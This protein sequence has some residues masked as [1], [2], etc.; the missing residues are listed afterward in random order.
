MSKKVKL[1]VIFLIVIVIAAGA[2][3]LLKPKVKDNFVERED[4]N[5][6]YSSLELSGSEPGKLTIRISDTLYPD[7]KTWQ[8]DFESKQVINEVRSVNWDDLTA[9]EFSYGAPKLR[10]TAAVDNQVI[11]EL[12]APADNGYWDKIRESI[13]SSL[14]FDQSVFVN[15]A[16]DT[17]NEAVIL[18]EEVIE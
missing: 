4:D 8:K 17:D 14:K 3:L 18:L 11:Y 12:E 9:V 6:I 15:P 10:K 13:L 7:L 2:W 5:T 1:V 16:A